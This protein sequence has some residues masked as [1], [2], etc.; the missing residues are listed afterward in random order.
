MPGMSA[1]EL[2]S[3]SSNEIRIRKEAARA[4]SVVGVVSI[5]LGLVVLVFSSLPVRLM[6][7]VWQLQLSGALT[8][9][10]SRS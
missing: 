6:D 3:S 4:F 9:G 10:G 5:G 1:T 8:A 7:P 2:R